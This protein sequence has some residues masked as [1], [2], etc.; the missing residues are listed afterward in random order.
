MKRGLET[1]FITVPQGYH[2]PAS[3]SRRSPSVSMRNRNEDVAANLRPDMLHYG[4]QKNWPQET[5]GSLV[6]DQ[7]VAAKLRFDMLHYKEQNRTMGLQ[8]DTAAEGY[9]GQSGARVQSPLLATRSDSPLWNRSTL[10]GSL[11]G[12]REFGP[13]ER[14]AQGGMTA[15]RSAER[16]SSRGR[17]A[18]E[19]DQSR[20]ENDKASH[21]PRSPR[22]ATSPKRGTGSRSPSPG[23]N[24]DKFRAEVPHATLMHS[25]QSQMPMPPDM[26]TLRWPS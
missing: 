25:G 13:G 3:S 22:R 5:A 9:S 11:S 10:S 24:W 8:P 21:N 26:N 12:G 2:K 7:D 16:E 19:L 18:C 15:G 20:S 17:R 6:P 1:Q 4:E 14:E 23:A